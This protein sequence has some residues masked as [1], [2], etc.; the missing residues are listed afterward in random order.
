LFSF[1]N[2]TSSVL[3]LNVGM[4]RTPLFPMHTREEI[5]PGPM[6]FI[7]A[8]SSVCRWVPS[9]NYLPQL[10]ICLYNY[11]IDLI[12]FTFNKHCKQCVQSKTSDIHIH[13]KPFPIVFSISGNKP[14]KGVILNSFLFL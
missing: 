1:T 11:L 13:T 5:L 8:I 6:A 7:Q 2:F 9:F 10:Q 4:P 3:F 14:K 12:T